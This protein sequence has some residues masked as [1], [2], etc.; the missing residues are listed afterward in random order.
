MTSLEPYRTRLSVLF[1]AD[2]PKA[3][4]LRRGPR[5]HFRLVAWDLRKDSF[6]PG[7]WMK[8][9]IKLWDLSPKGSKLL[10]WAMQHRARYREPV[11]NAAPYEPLDFF[12][13]GGAIAKGR[14]RRKV[15]RY[16]RD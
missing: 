2:A 4:I 3:V 12:Y 16:M 8:G 1:A 15:P 10:Y 6:T 13:R 9:V 7:Q 5:T 11:A 14:G